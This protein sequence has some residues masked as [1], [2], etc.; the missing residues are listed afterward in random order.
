MKNEL[1]EEFAELAKPQVTVVSAV[2][3]GVKVGLGAFIEGM[4]KAFDIAQSSPT[5]KD[6]AN[7][8]RTELAAALFNG[9]PYVMYQRGMHG[10]PEKGGEE[11]KEPSPEVEQP[12]IKQS[13]GIHL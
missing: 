7:H 12:E 11:L 2:T 6:M 13:H 9:S 5:L 8:G 1:K 3:E 10:Q 4:G